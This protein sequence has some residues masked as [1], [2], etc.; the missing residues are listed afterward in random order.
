[1]DTIISV[2]FLYIFIIIEIYLSYFLYFTVLCHCS[3]YL[4]LFTE[5]KIPPPNQE[6][7]HLLA[8]VVSHYT[9]NNIFNQFY[10]VMM[11]FYNS[12]FIL[13]YYYTLDIRMHKYTLSVNVYTSM[14]T[15]DTQTYIGV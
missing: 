2:I 3:H 10:T 5:G 1:M 4:I 12:T 13:L 11:I 9:C 8:S 7:L 14:Y 6:M 15:G